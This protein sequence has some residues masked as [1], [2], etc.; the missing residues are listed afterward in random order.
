MTETLEFAVKLA[1]QAGELL[2]GHFTLSGTHAHLKE[3]RSVVTEADIAADRLI[4]NAIHSTYPEDG[5][6][7]EELYNVSPLEKKAVWVIDPLDGTTNFSLGL[8]I[9]GISIARLVDGFPALG[10]L[11]F[12][13]LGE[14]YTAQSGLG[15]SLNGTPIHA[16]GSPSNPTATF[17]ACCSRTHRR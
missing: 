13:T 17:F 10:V 3:D 8:P 14:L 12:P 5:L 6:L 1:R 4:A 9:W 15:A 11:Y 7:S 16:A 2:L